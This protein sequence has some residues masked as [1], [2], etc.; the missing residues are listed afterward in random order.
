MC[1]IYCEDKRWRI[2]GGS[3]EDSSKQV[4]SEKERDN[5]VIPLKVTA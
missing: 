2:A 5:V 1:V 3:E 4:K